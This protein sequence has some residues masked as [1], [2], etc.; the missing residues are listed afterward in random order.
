MSTIGRG[1][2]RLGAIARGLAKLRGRS[3]EELRERAM[4]RIRA[5]L[6]RRHLS[7]MV[8]EPSDMQLHALLAPGALSG[9]GPSAEALH[10]DFINRATPRF[11][12]GV[13]DGTT[14]AELRLPR[15]T[16]AR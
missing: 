2:E 5:E 6:E 7:R 8:R 1:R 10:R 16:A 12:A 14:A 11:F 15:W 3:I 9:N 4:Q 13:R